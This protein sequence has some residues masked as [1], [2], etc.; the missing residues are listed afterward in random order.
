[1]AGAP[2]HPPPKKGL[3]LGSSQMHLPAC[4]PTWPARVSC[5]HSKDADHDHHNNN[6]QNHN[7]GH[8][9]NKDAGYT[10]DED[11]NDDLDA[12]FLDL[13]LFLIM[14]FFNELTGIKRQL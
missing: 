14:V 4:G 5:H 13:L 11:D 9:H 8:D 1:M 2:L 12:A 10:D 3:D 6:D 7:H